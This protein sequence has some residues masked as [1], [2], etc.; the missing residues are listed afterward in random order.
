MKDLIAQPLLQ[1]LKKM[2][3]KPY[4]YKGQNIIISNYTVLS[5][6]GKTLIDLQGAR[7]LKIRDLSQFL[8]E[9]LP[10]DSEDETVV[11]TEVVQ[12]TNNLL[13]TLQQTL[14]DNIEKVK[15]DPAYIK[16]ANTVNSSVN[17]LI[18]LAKIQISVSKI[19]NR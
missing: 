18:G 13:T 12:Q 11:S 5:D 17:S 14:L 16:Q 3:G 15:K 1:R 19:K 4:M 6:E 8:N 7:P 9:C 10:V 2:I